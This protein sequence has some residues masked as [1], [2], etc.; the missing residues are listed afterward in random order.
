MRQRQKTRWVL[1]DPYRDIEARLIT[2]RRWVVDAEQ[3]IHNTPNDHMGDVSVVE[4]VALVVKTR[5]EINKL[6]AIAD[7]LNP[8]YY[9]GKRRPQRYSHT[10]HRG[11]KRAGFDQGRHSI[12]VKPH[13]L[14]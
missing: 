9:L 4:T 5:K 10:K 8:S 2:L 14:S 11:G 13:T 3:L 12:A 7:E 1:C 6:D